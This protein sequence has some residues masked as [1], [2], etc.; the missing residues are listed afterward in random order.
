MQ[1]APTINSCQHRSDPLTLARVHTAL[2]RHIRSVGP[3]QNRASDDVSQQGC[4]ALPDPERTLSHRG[5]ANME[6]GKRAVVEWSVD[7]GPRVMAPA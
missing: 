7:A 1:S 6:H 2:D 5:V 4:S 3:A